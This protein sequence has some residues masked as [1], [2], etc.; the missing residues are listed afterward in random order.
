MKQTPLVLQLE[1][2][3]CERVRGHFLQCDVIFRKFLGSLHETCSSL[4]SLC[5]LSWSRFSQLSLQFHTFVLT[6]SLTHTHI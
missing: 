4:S 1:S 3:T 2:S 5:F 6:L